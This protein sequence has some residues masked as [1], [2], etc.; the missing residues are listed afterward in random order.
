M[1]GPVLNRHSPF[2]L[3]LTPNLYLPPFI[4]V[5]KKKNLTWKKCWGALTSLSPQFTYVIM[6][7]VTSKKPR[8]LHYGKLLRRQMQVSTS[9]RPLPSFMQITNKKI[10]C[11]PLE[12]SHFLG[13]YVGLGGM[14]F[15]QVYAAS[16]DE[17]PTL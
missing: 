10:F 4:S 5:V 8:C 3:T 14:K 12:G 6:I 2:S 15:R 17:K 13:C 7:I 11:C 1:S 9:C 16:Y